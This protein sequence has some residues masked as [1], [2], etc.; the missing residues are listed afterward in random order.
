MIVS[1]YLPQL[2]SDS[3]MVSEMVSEN[4][5]EYKIILMSTIKKIIDNRL[6]LKKEIKTTFFFYY[7]TEC[8]PE[9][10]VFLKIEGAH[11]C[12]DASSMAKEIC[13]EVQDLH[14]T[15]AVASHLKF[16]ECH[17]TIG[18]VQVIDASVSK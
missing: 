6:S 16:I 10:C 14:N 5:K 13:N 7:Y 3:P 1:V 8:H 4:V 18:G 2:F 17:V 9:I 15:L 11:C 12:D